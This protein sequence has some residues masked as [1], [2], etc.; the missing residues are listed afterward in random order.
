MRIE[1]N[2]RPHAVP[3]GTTVE[4]LLG[5][6]RLRPEVAAVEVD[7]QLVPRAER[8]ARVLAAGARV[9]VVTLVGGG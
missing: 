8:A 6:L 7:E 9:E 2:G 1:L 4:A 3:E 5:S